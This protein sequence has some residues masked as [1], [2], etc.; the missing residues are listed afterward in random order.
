[1]YHFSG[2]IKK[3]F[4]KMPPSRT[5]RLWCYNVLNIILGWAFA[6]YPILQHS[7]NTQIITA[8]GIPIPFSLDTDLAPDV[9]KHSGTLVRNSF[10]HWTLPMLKWEKVPVSINSDPLYKPKSLLTYH[11]ALPW[12]QETTGIH[13]LDQWCKV[14]SNYFIVS[15]KVDQRAGLRRT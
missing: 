10:Q 9:L 4:M 3:Q 5:A 2:P 14:K 6:H 8:T 15:P 7:P 1:M 11:V 12:S 13:C